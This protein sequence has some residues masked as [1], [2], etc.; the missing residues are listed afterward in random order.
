MTAQMMPT[1][2][3]V[4]I[5]ER[6]NLAPYSTMKVGGPADYFATVATTEQMLKV[7]RWHAPSAPP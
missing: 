2:S 5:G 6:V 1:I 3:G 7:A 4:E